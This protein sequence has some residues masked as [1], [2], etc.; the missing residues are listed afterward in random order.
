MTS[1]TPPPPD[2]TEPVPGQDSDP[3]GASPL[4]AVPASTRAG[5]VAVVGRPNA[6]KSTLMNAMVGEKLSIVTPKAQT[7]WQRVTGI[8]TDQDF[9]MIFLDTPGLLEVKD[10]FQASMLDAAHEALAEA[11]VLLV[12]LDAKRFKVDRDGP[13]LRE[14]VELSRAPRV[15]VVNKIDLVGPER[16][17]EVA[18][19]ASDA[20]D[21]EVI[22]ASALTGEGVEELLGALRERLPES[23]FFY[24]PDEIASEPVR[25]FVAEMIRETVFEQF[26]EEIPYSVACEVG[27]FRESQDPVYIQ[28][29]LFADRQPQKRILVGDKGSAIRKL[30]KASREKIER[31]L[32]RPVY[33]DLWVKVLPGW[34][35]Q[36]RHLRRLGFRVR[37]ERPDSGG[38]G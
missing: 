13:V 25:F 9:Q 8:L 1:H 16:V 14:S 21:A 5:Y 38:K 35:R 10:R 17:E 30:G 12:V 28:A 33:L 15:A 29:T 18:R 24:P 7:T 20:L 34:R 23:P 22:P 11:D 6:G 3:Q 19:W 32:D 31:F 2:D 27:E 26:R 37:D 36:P 4:S